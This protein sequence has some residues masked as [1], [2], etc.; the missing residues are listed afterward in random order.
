MEVGISFFFFFSLCRSPLACHLQP[1]RNYRVEHKRII[2][3]AH[4]SPGVFFF[5]PRAGEYNK[6]E[7]E[8]ILNGSE[9][10]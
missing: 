2:G 3:V 9:K 5:E 1:T 8:Y 7:K 4:R 10:F 6:N